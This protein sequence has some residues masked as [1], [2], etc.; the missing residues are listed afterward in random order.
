MDDEA[1]SSILDLHDKVALVTGSGRGIG[2]GIACRLAE[3]G[4]T[5]VVADVDAGLAAETVT[6]IQH[7]GGKATS[8]AADAS[9]VSEA[10]RVMRFAL[11]SFGDLDI[12]VNNAAMFPPVPVLD[13]SEQQWDRLMDLNLKGAFFLAQAAAKTM[14]AKGHGGKIINIAS[15]GW[16]IPAGLLSHYDASKGGMVSFTRS[17]AKELGPHGIHVN[18][19]APGIV[20]TPGGDLASAKMAETMK[21][22]LDVLPIRS[23]L[24][25]NG[26]A[27]DIAKVA[28]FLATGLSDYVT[29]SVIEVGGGYHLC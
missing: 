2:R 3:A 19:I 23:V 5:L 24:G 14:I 26:V 10:D 18:A 13:I 4:A 7:A 9:K 8:I 17:F 16:A 28:Y 20:M 11:E 22:N 1:L 25:R 15:L 21:L 29:G 27:D 6:R 12:L